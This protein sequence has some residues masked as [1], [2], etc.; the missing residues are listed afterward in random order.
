MRTFLLLIALVFSAPAVSVAVDE[1]PVSPSEFRDYAEGWTLYFERDG[2]V[3]GSES[4]STGG[5][6]RWRYNDGSCV[7]GAWRP[8]G[9]QLCFLY[10]A[11][12]N[13]DREVLC[14][15]VLRDKDGLIARLLN[16][17]EN[18]GLELRV[19]RRDKKPLLCGDPGTST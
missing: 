16:G 10:E 15:R 4:F 19:V 5:D 2:E 1:T 17:G 8:H 12:E 14:W 9:A 3:F 13:Q 18:A 11:D 7:R 6:T